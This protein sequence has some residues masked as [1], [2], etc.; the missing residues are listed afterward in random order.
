MELKLSNNC[1]YGNG[2]GMHLLGFF[3]A[4]D[5]TGGMGGEAQFIIPRAEPGV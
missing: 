4:P 2:G 1:N 3:A 5:G